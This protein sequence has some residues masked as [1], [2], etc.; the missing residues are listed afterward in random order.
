MIKEIHEYEDAIKA[1]LDL[2]DAPQVE[3]RVMPENEAENNRPYEK[4]LIT[5]AYAGSRF[6][7]TKQIGT[8][9]QEEISLFEVIFQS[10]KLRGDGGIYKMLQMAKRQLIG[11]KVFDSKKIYIDTGDAEK[12]GFVERSED[13]IFMFR[14]LICIET[15]FVQAVEEP[16]YD[17][18]LL[19]KASPHVAEI[20]N[21]SNNGIGYNFRI[22]EN[23]EIE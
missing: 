9:S 1:R 19:V 13:Q 16:E 18:P 17:G 4:G 7:K 20:N 21:E 10:K 11:Y 5:V 14:M 8:Q 22:G 15:T 12:V 3:T 2:A 6:S 23:N